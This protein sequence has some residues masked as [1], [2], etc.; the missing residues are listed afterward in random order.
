MVCGIKKAVFADGKLSLHEDK[1][2]AGGNGNIL[3]SFKPVNIGEKIC[4]R[5]GILKPEADILMEFYLTDRVAHPTGDWPACASVITPSYPKI[6]ARSCTYTR[7]ESCGLGDCSRSPEMDLVSPARGGA[8]GND[9]SPS[10]SP[11]AASPAGKAPVV[12]LG[13]SEGFCSCC[14]LPIINAHWCWK[15]SKGG[16]QTNGELL[17]KV[18]QLMSFPQAFRVAAK[19]RSG[20]T[21]CCHC[22]DDTCVFIQLEFSWGW[23]A[24]EAQRLQSWIWKHLWKDSPVLPLIEQS[25]QS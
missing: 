20:S 18:V 21:A 6:S 10:H 8:S 19:A 11:H 3:L 4:F 7:E 22:T 25:H 17:E 12:R 23:K 9:E 2:F 15:N 16:I 13:C 24:P 14:K 1:L 5:V